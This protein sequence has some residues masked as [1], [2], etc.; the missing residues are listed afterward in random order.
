MK[1]WIV[2]KVKIWE[3]H[4]NTKMTQ[5]FN[6]LISSCEKLAQ[7]VKGQLVEDKEEKPILMETQKSRGIDYLIKSELANNELLAAVQSEIA[8]NVFFI[9]QSVM[10]T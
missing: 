4:S 2:L 6:E 8:G 7:E 3:E 10:I 5:N 1:T 9:W